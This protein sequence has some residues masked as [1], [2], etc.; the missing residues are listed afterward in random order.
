MTILPNDEQL[1]SAILSLIQEHHVSELVVGISE[2]QMAEKTQNFVSRLREVTD[3]PINLVD[4]TLTSH[5]VH[6]WLRQAPAHKRR[7]PIDHLA[8]AVIL[9]NFLTERETYAH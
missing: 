5:Q 7:G 8:A 9:E 3:L 4:E 6:E 2:N 1:L